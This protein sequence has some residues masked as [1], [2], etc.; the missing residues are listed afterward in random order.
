MNVTP[1]VSFEIQLLLSSFAAVSSVLFPVAKI[2]AKLNPVKNNLTVEVL[3][4]N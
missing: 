3:L 1:L 2:K 4:D